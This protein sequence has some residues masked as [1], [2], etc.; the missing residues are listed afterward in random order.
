MS[1]PTL[2]KMD[3]SGKIREWSV[4]TDGNTYSVSH[5]LVDGA[6]QTS[7]VTCEPKNVGRSNETTGEQQAISEAQGLWNK[8]RDRKGYTEEIPTDRPN[9]PMLAQKYHES[10]HKIKFPAV[11]SPKI[12][13]FRMV[14]TVEDGQITTLSR[15][16]TE[17]TGIEHIT[18]EYAGFGNVVLDGELYTHTLSFEDFSST[19][20]GGDPNDPRMKEVF[21]YAFDIIN[22]D[23]YHDRVLQLQKLITLK[24]LKHT[25]I[26]PWVVVTSHEEIEELHREYVDIHEEEGT[27]VRNLNSLY[28][29]NKRSYDLQKYKDHIDE[30]FEVIGWKRGKGKFENVP[31]FLLL[32]EGGEFSAT[33][34][35][36]QSIREFYLENA[37]SY[38]GKKATVRFFEYTSKNIP[39]FPVLVR[40]REDGL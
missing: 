6:K 36:D 33:P 38:I 25:T 17:F 5:G 37:D 30:E 7:L 9:M 31:T 35:G 16:N 15:S 2:Y 26:V 8:Q 23:I 20:R 39:R 1:W 28:Q 21:F 32:A 11:C 22:D 40:F 29:I 18:N 34:E 3:S 12:D 27:M 13:G 14:L 4:S 10:K 24:G 19:V